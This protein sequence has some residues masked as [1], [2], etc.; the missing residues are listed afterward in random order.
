MG[1]VRFVTYAVEPDLIV[2]SYEELNLIF[3]DQIHLQ[4]VSFGPRE[5]FPGEIIPITF[6]WMTE[7]EV[8]KR[9]KVFLHLVDE[10]G[11]IAA[12]RDS[13]P[14][15]GGAITSSW[16]PGEIIEDNHGILLPKELSPGEYTLLIGL[17]DIADPVN[18]LIIQSE[19][20]EFDAYPLA[21]MTIKSSSGLEGS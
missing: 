9:Y 7:T 2:E 3:G 18:R 6:H 16:I 1:D 14:G 10:N 13:E 19:E 12:Q 4:S 11:Q 5:L 17:Y 8:K 20:G 15:G 21:I